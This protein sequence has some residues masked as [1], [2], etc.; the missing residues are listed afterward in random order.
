MIFLLKKAF[1]LCFLQINKNFDNIL[2]LFFFL[3]H[4]TKEKTTVWTKGNIL[5]T[6]F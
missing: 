1:Y 6:L 5:K 2:R 3:P 4:K